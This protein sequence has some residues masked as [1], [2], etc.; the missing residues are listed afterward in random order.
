MSMVR[1]GR[2][3]LG[4]GGAVALAVAAGAY[5]QTTGTASGP[6]A[7]PAPGAR[8]QAA[9]GL[10][11]AAAWADSLSAHRAPRQPAPG[12]TDDLIVLMDQPPLARVAPADRATAARA[13]DEA[14]SR[15]EAAVAGLG[16][17]VTARW[18][19]VVAGIAVRIPAGH[20]DAVA[21]LP[22]VRSAVPVQYL[23]PAAQAQGPAGPSG[24]TAAPQLP[25]QVH[26]AHIALIDTAVNPM[27]PQLGGGMGPTF[28][29]IGGADL[30]DGDGDPTVGSDAPRW[31]AHGTQMAGLVLTSAALA[32]LSPQRT[33]RLLAYRVV[34]SEHVDG[35]DIPLARTDRVLSALERAVD[36][37]GDGNPEDRAEVI[38]LGVAGGFA[39]GGLDPV[40]LATDGATRAGSRVVAPAGNDGPTFARMGSVGQPAAGSRVLTVGG[41]AGQESPR[42]AGLRV[43]IGPAGASLN[44]LPLLGPDPAAGAAPLVVLPGNGGPGDGLDASQYAQAAADGHDPRGAIVVVARGDGS[45]QRKAELAAAAGARAVVVW[46]QAGV[47]VFPSGASDGGPVLP[48]LGAGQQQGQALVDLLTRT[49]D[50]IA[51]VH[52]DQRLPAPAAVASFSSNG[53]TADGR[54][55][56]DLVA[57]SV[58]VPTAWFPGPAGEAASATMTGTSAAAAQAAAVALRTR[59]DRPALGADDVRALM[60]QS[61]RPLSAVRLVAQGGGELAM[62]G[63]P[64][65]VLRPP[66]ITGRAPRRGRPAVRVQ[67]DDVS[68]SGGRY[69]LAVLSA[70]NHVMARGPVVS[71]PAGGGARAVLRLPSSRRGWSG[72][73]ALL[74]AISGALVT[75]APAATFPPRRGRSD[76]LG[77]PVVRTVGGVTQAVVRIGRLAR[78]GDRLRSAPLR[79]VRLR[80]AP[81]DGS[82]PLVLTGTRDPHDWAA[83]T[84]RFVISRRLPSGGTVPAGRYRLL[85][86]ARTPEGTPISTR[87][88]LFTLR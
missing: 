78:L 47:G 9:T 29:I 26:P 22:G 33:P 10:A 83:G 41:M 38:L 46:D 35:R 84:Y 12:A 62:P 28:P 45:L 51:E 65:A 4:A 86:E 66:I 30:V 72:R 5:A 67:A 34:A 59:I 80:L 1:R 55:K 14:R 8:A 54:V 58:D 24:G 68:G 64:R 23:A 3:L 49:P 43:R 82:Q 37:N 74:D 39:G 19:V 17:T 6:E 21:A 50:A 69:R 79:A 31:E 70:D 85:V 13:L 81:T 25:A 61:G 77:V 2:V 16:G 18:S 57:P 36:P 60:V 87:S 56:P 32:G 27:A 53:P 73:V 44:E 48:V 52:T 42:T 20:A 15:L 11:A 40:A 76:D 7:A 75:S 88:G 63:T 71:V